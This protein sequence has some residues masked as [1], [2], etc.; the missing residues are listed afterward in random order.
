MRTF[1]V[2]LIAVLSG[3]N[4]FF[5]D[6]GK[7]PEKCDLATSAREATSEIAPQALRDP[8]HLT[9]EAFGG[10]GCDPECGPC[11]PE[12]ADLAPIPTWGQCGSFCEAL[13]ESDCQ[14]NSEC[15][16]VKDARCAI[17]EDCITDF[18][19][20]FPIDS[21]PDPAVDC[22]AARDGWTCSRS[23][24]CTALH[25]RAACPGPHH[26]ACDRPFAVCVPEGR[27]PGRCTE[28]VT[29]D[30]AAPSCPSGSTPGVENGCYTGACIPL[31][32]CES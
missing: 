23:A 13:T 2:A 25:E 24:G 30:K 1:A 5:D 16:V 17:A 19:G 9:C 8:D 18:V 4:L 20:C 6:G 27:S 15:R 7:R 21:A 26:P 3:C 12:A 22:F 14:A 10:S 11:P 31:S 32:F 28:P 29:C